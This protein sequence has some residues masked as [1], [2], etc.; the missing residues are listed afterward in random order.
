MILRY[1]DTNGRENEMQERRIE[2]LSN[3]QAKRRAAQIHNERIER[4][5]YF[6][7]SRVVDP[8]GPS[9]RNALAIKADRTSGTPRRTRGGHRMRARAAKRM[10]QVMAGREKMNALLRRAGIRASL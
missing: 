10:D 6:S 5:G 8:R 4:D 3:S 9:Q 7:G 2:I 1:N